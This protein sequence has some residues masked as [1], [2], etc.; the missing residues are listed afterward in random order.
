MAMKTAFELRRSSEAKEKPGI[1]WREQARIMG[2]VLP[3]MWP[4]GE[5]GIKLR[6]LGAAVLVLATKVITVAM[7]VLYKDVV[8]ALSSGANAAVAVPLLLVLGYG[9]AR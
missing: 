5:Y 1:P 7:P 3:L 8:D 9:V 6:V 2:R 4:A